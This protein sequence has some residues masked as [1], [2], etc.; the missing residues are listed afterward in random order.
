V[1]EEPIFKLSSGKLSRY[2]IDLKQVTLDPEGAYLVGKFMYEL[3]RQF[4][5]QGVG[6]LTLGAD[7]IAY[8]VAFVQCRLAEGRAWRWW[9]FLRWWI[10]RRGHRRI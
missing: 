2:Y 1:A 6:G 9:A 7:P 5:V 8:A 4:G 3:V 10:E